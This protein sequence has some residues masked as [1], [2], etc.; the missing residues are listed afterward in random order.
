[1]YIGL[2]EII[3]IIVVAL[4]V[5]KPNKLHDLADSIGKAMKEYD[6]EKNDIRENIVDPIKKDVID[7]IKEVKTDIQESIKL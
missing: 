5:I 2:T 1:M 3:L 6:K 7:P 4:A